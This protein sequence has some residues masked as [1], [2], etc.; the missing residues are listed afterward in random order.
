[1][2]DMVAGAAAR[3]RK[4]LATGV[5]A[6]PSIF[7]PSIAYYLFLAVVLAWMEVTAMQ[8]WRLSTG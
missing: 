6:T 8:L 1:M 3:A 4:R 5:V 2:K 7:L